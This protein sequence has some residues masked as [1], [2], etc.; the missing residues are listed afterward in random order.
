MRRF[1][2]WLTVFRRSVQ[3][4]KA[5]RCAAWILP[6]VLMLAAPMVEISEAAVQESIEE[7][8]AEADRLL[9]QGNGQLDAGQFREALQSLLPALEIYQKVGDL[10]SQGITLGDLGL[11]YHN[12]GQYQQAIELYELAIGIAREIGNQR[13]EGAVL[14]SLGHSYEA[15]GQHQQAINL[16]EQQLSIV[17]AVGHRRGEA[18]ALGNLGVAYRNLGQEQQA[19]AAY[20]QALAITREIGD[21][22]GEGAFLSNIGAVLAGQ[23][24]TEQAIGVLQQSVE[25]YETIR[26]NIRDLSQAQQQAFL[27]SVSRTYIVLV[28]LL[29]Q[30]NRAEEAQRILELIGNESE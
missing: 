20:Q 21:L 28:R 18:Y 11:V 7:Q 10:R 27:D 8:Q 15:L 17:R 4:R 14:G 29:Q 24:Q 13:N 25:V 5:G 23:N 26:H 30:E 9:Q 16:Y 2:S 1:I 3:G 19:I 12:L 22:P 6:G